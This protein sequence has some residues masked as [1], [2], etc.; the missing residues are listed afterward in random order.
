MLGLSCREGSTLRAPQ[1]MSMDIAHE[2]GHSAR[3]AGYTIADDEMAVGSTL[4]G[5]TVCTL[6]KGTGAIEK[7]YSIEAGVTIFGALVLHHWDEQTGMQLS[8]IETGAF[9]L[10][11][12]HQERTFKLP[13]K[14]EVHEDI[15]VLS[16][17]PGSD[18][19]VDP[20]AVYYTVEL[21][22]ESDIDAHIGTYAFCQLRGTTPHDID[23]AFDKRLG[24]LVVWNQSNPDLVRV[25]GCSEKPTSYETTLDYAKAVGM[26]GPGL[27]SGS[28]ECSPGDNLGVI[29]LSHTIKAGERVNFFY[30]LSF[31]N[32]GRSGAAA[33]YRACPSAE[34]A[35]A[36][37]SAYY[38]EVLG[39]SVV[40]T[41]DPAVNRGV[42]WA[43][44]N[45]LRVQ[46]KA[47]TGWCFVNDPTR[48]NN[49]V[50]R[51]TA[52]FGYGADY[53]T[54]EFARESL[55]AYVRLQEPS[56]LIVEY[57]DIR[58]GKTEDYGLNINDNTALLI[59]ALWHHYTATGADDFLREVYPSAAKAARYILSQRNDQ[60]LVWCT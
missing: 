45:M 58:T 8:P 23:A 19:S 53:L 11:P 43:K 38:D 30:L 40:L 5:P 27:L 13:N 32:K 15:F 10:Y 37:T 4:G 60:G 24:A 2:I 21:H 47:Q 52:W 9:T 59:L 6:I 22:N 20:P 29:H 56:G 18:G 39:R 49:S 25:F 41:P 31:S 26:H 55:L 12:E 17:Q 50:A 51:D 42:L 36:R 35:L 16:G 44:A 46:C 34:D 14:V 3:D 54:P 48:S 33:A 28:T 57:Y 1:S 7:V